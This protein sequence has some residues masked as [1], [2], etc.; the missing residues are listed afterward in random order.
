[1][2]LGGDSPHRCVRCGGSAWVETRDGDGESCPVCQAAPASEA[3]EL[4]EA[5]GAG[6]QSPARDPFNPPQELENECRKYIE[7]LRAYKT[8]QPQTSPPTLVGGPN[9]LDRHQAA[10]VLTAAAGWIEFLSTEMSDRQAVARVFKAAT[11]WMD[12]Y[13][14][15]VHKGKLSGLREEQFERLQDYQYRLDLL[16]AEISAL[17]GLAA[18][19]KAIYQAASRNLSGE[20]APRN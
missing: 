15:F 4:R 13:V 2:R 1:V 12:R 20:I 16:E 19:Q 10:V 6:A 11:N 14:R 3:E 8:P 9:S 5:L 18:Q 7:A 17:E